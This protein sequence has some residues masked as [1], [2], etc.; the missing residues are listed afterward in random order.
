[1]IVNANFSCNLI[2]NESMINEPKISNAY[3]KLTFQLYLR[4][5]SNRYEVIPLGNSLKTKKFR[6][7][8]QKGTFHHKSF[9]KYKYSNF[10]LTFVRTF[11]N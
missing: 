11:T 6:K 4:H 9:M 1:M 8:Q 10:F 3:I 2:Q 5:W 7:T